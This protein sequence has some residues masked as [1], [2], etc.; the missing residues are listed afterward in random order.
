MEPKLVTQYAT[1]LTSL[2]GTDFQEEVCTRFQAF[3]L[4]FQTV[5]SHPQGDAGL[6]AFSHDGTQAYCCYGMQLEH[7]GTNKKR[8]KALVEKF[9]SDLRRLF[10]LE[11][12]KDALLH[13]ENREMKT[14]LPTGKRIRHID[15]LTNWF[16]SH[17]VLNP[18]LDAAGEYRA[19]SQC[20]YVEQNASV[21]VLGPKE[22]ANR[23][24]VDELTMARAD[25]RSLL[26]RLVKASQVVKIAGADTFDSKMQKL[27]DAHPSKISSIDMMADRFRDQWRMAIAFDDHLDKTAPNLHKVLETCRAQINLKVAVE[28]VSSNA[29]WDVLKAADYIAKQLTQDAFEPQFKGLWGVVA[30]GEV[31]RLIGEC[32]INWES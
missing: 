30:S 15:L 8:Q 22:I 31:A 29:P 19:S 3:V 9:S 12:S 20:R 17:R 2:S 6:D 32:P 1:L 10:E 27:R 21:T 13:E 5:P 24:P 25:Q 16:D 23:F 26:Q 14:I 4:G 7:H 18:I 11:K 28:M